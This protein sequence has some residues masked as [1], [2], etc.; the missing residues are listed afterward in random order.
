MKV[1][2]F[3]L[4]IK[5]F[6][7]RRRMA[8]LAAVTALFFLSAGIAAHAQSS[9]QTL[10]NATRQLAK[11][12]L[13]SVVTVAV[14]TTIQV[15]NNEGF[16]QFFFFNPFGGNSNNGKTPPKPRQYEQAGLGSGVIVRKEGSTYYVLTNAHVIEDADT[17]ELI[18]YE[19]DKFRAK[20]VGKDTARDIAVV[21]F[22]S[23]KT[24][25]VAK[26][27]NSDDLVPG[28]LV[29]AI[30]SPHGFEF[31]VTFGIVSA[32]KRSAPES[33]SLRGN[34][35]EYIQ[36][37]A[38]VNRGSSGGPL[39]NI[40]GQV[41]GINTWIYSQ[42]GENAGLSFA[43]P[44][45]NVVQSIDAVIKNGEVTYGWL[46]VRHST[47]MSDRMGSLTGSDSGAFVA[48]VYRDS[49]AEKGG[50][51]PGDIITSVDGKPIKQANDLL[52]SI[53]GKKPG[54]RIKASV[55]RGGAEQSL[56]VV[57]GKREDDKTLESNDV[58]AWPG[59]TAIDLTKYV[60]DRFS[61][62]SKNGVM[63]TDVD[64]A[65]SAEA[66]GLE[67]F[68]IIEKVNDEAIKNLK[69]F[70][71]ALNRSKN[72]QLLFRVNRGG[73]IFIVGIAKS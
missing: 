12:A 31:S 52:S 57:L 72:G 7:M 43:V 48:R 27:G 15:S 63:I 22:E 9:L 56:N 19:Q 11:S 64:E 51:L 14:E 42:T 21:S 37:D 65:S 58:P 39:L 41:I 24:L 71:G 70:Y 18:S 30:G 50:I 67:R 23:N 69:E 13:P 36:T 20:V 68:D 40:D 6:F 5:R 2:E 53:A 35:T 1:S 47:V 46:G 33:G 16:G 55:I 44:I 73:S 66:A 45:N 25:P 3:S 28:D 26:L 60:R 62:S 61:I 29:F 17:I 32:V 8:A 4:S 59:F 49:P 54:S 38:A 34:M 10:Q